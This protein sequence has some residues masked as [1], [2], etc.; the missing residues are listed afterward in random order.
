[1]SLSSDDLMSIFYQPLISRIYVLSCSCMVGAVV[2]L[3]PGLWSFP[4]LMILHL[5]D[6]WLLSFPVKTHSK[7]VLISQK[8][9]FQHVET[10]YEISGPHGNPTSGHRTLLS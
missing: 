10:A 3:L 8:P 2:I 5:L 9:L 4:F 1:M 6:S 7:I